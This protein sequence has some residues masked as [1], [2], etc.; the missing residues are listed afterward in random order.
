MTV[1]FRFPILLLISSSLCVFPQTKSDPYPKLGMQSG[2]VYSFNDIETL[3][4]VTGNLTFHI[5]IG[6]LGPDR[7]GTEHSL[8][9]VYNSKIWEPST[10]ETTING[11]AVTNPS[12]QS[13]TTGGWR[14]SMGYDLETEV[15]PGVDQIPCTDPSSGSDLNLLIKY[16]VKTRIVFPDGSR[17]LLRPRVVDNSDAFLEYDNGGDG[18][19]RFY[20]TAQ[21]NYENLCNA[22]VA[23]AAVPNPLIYYSTDGSFLRVVVTRGATTTANP[24]PTTSWAMYFKNGDYVLGGGT[25]AQQ[26]CDRNNNCLTINNVIEGTNYYTTLT[27]DPGRQIK[28]AYTGCGTVSPATPCGQTPLGH[29]T[30]SVDVITIPG[31]NL[32]TL[33]WTVAWANFA[34]SSLTVTS[35]GS[36]GTSRTPAVLGG[37][38]WMV[39]SIQPPVES[40]EGPYSFSYDPNWGRLKKAVSPTGA[41]AFYTYWLE[42]PNA[43]KCIPTAPSSG[44]S[45]AW[46]DLLADY[47]CYN[48]TY[49]ANASQYPDDASAS[50]NSLTADETSTL[51]ISQ[52][53]L[54]GA[55]IYYQSDFTG[56]DGG[57]TTTHFDCA[58]GNN[59]C[60]S[61]DVGPSPGNWQSGLVSQID[62][63]DGTIVV[64]TWAK[65]PLFGTGCASGNTSCAVFPYDSQNTYMSSSSRSVAG[66][67]LIDGNNPAG[68]NATINYAVDLNGNPLTTTENDWD[69]T[70]LRRTSYTY[71]SPTPAATADNSAP[72]SDNPNV[73]WK[74]PGPGILNLPLTKKIEGTNSPIS[75]E[76][77][78]YDISPTPTLGN[79]TT[80]A[81]Y[82]NGPPSQPFAC[83]ASRKTSTADYVTN[84]FFYV[85]N[86]IYPQ[87]GILL[88][89]VDGRGYATQFRYDAD[90]LYIIEKDEACNKA[91][92]DPTAKCVLPEARRSTYVT[93]WNTGKR[94]SA[95]DADN[96]TT[97]N[98]NYSSG[99][100][101]DW[102]SRPTMVTDPAGA[103][104][105]FVFN[106]GVNPRSVKTSSPLDTAPGNGLTG[107]RTVPSVNCYDSVGR[108]TLTIVSEAGVAVD[109]SSTSS[110]VIMVQRQYTYRTATSGCG[111]GSGGRFECVSNPFRSTSDAT[112][113][114]VQ[115]AYDNAGRLTE[116]AHQNGTQTQKVS[117]ATYSYNGYCT[118]AYDE[119]A[120]SGANTGNPGIIK[121]T[122][123]DALGRI[124]FVIEKGK[125]QSNSDS[126]PKTTYAYDGLGNLTSVQQYSPDSAVTQTRTFNYDA[127]GR[128]TTAANPESGTINYRYDNNGNLLAKWDSRPVTTCYWPTTD[129]TA[130]GTSAQS[131][132]GAAGVG[133]DGLNRLLGK[134][135]SDGTP[136]V[137]YTY[138]NTGCSTPFGVGRLTQTTST[139]QWT[140]SSGGTVTNPETVSYTAFDQVGRVLQHSQQNPL[141]NSGTPAQFSY[142]YNQA[143]ALTAMTYPSGRSITTTYDAAG[144]AKG[145]QGALNSATTYYAYAGA[146]L[147]YSPH[148]AISQIS[149]SGGS[150]GTS[151]TMTENRAYNARLQP[152]SISAVSTN[153]ANPALRSFGYT[154]AGGSAPDGADNNGNV[155]SQT[156]SGTG[157]AS[158]V[159][160]TYTYDWA[161]RI[162]GANETVSNWS[163]QFTCDQFGNC[164]TTGTGTASNTPASLGNFST[165]NNRTN[166]N[167]AVYDPAGNQTG[168]GALGMTYDAE[169]RMTGSIIGGTLTIY[170]YDADGQR[171]AKVDCAS[172]DATCTEDSPSAA[173][174]WYVYD[175]HGELAAE[176][177][178]TADTSA[179]TTCYVVADHLGSTRLKA[180]S[181]GA[182]KDCHDYYPFGAEI[183]SST[184]APM[185]R[186][187][188]YSTTGAT[189]VLFTG[190]IRDGET[191]SSA[192]GGLDYFGARYMASAQGRFTSPDLVGPDLLNP[193]TLNKY[194]Y[195]LN[196][197]YRYVDPNG[198]YEE[199]V[200]RGLT[201][202]MAF[203]VGLSSQTAA[204]IASG[205][206]GVDDNPS[207]SPMWPVPC[208]GADKIRA[209]YHF[210][211]DARRA[212]MYSHFEGTL[213]A[214]D[215]GTFLH[216]EQDS[217]SHAGFGPVAG[218][219]SAGT[220]PDKTYND[221]AKA[222]RM[223]KDTYD[224]LIKASG[225]LTRTAGAIDWKAINPYVQRFNRATT[226]K[227]KSKAL[228]ELREEVF[229]FRKEEMIRE[230]EFR[231]T[232]AC[233]AENSSCGPH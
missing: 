227:E 68:T 148:G 160:Q 93:D 173:I 50:S 218:H 71:S 197:P 179:C 188:C 92:S 109:C 73:Y 66:F 189:G 111:V 230:A 135:Y 115:K 61:Y 36:D 87:Y 140:N 39:T 114:W 222:D 157:L 105:S 33:N 45:P 131:T 156:I 22:T 85:Q 14:Y 29:G 163:Q 154:Y 88:A 211:T 128:L 198:M 82:I 23:F 17:H 108:L 32:S 67:T 60:F 104:T 4:H 224:I 120:T 172:G 65:N 27:D 141:M 167:N 113:G 59:Y 42:S 53:A 187:G 20:P 233:Q 175:A 232:G 149:L 205:N 44:T 231:R 196:N 19:Y 110:N 94:R 31:F 217:F 137:A 9:L 25:N 225:L 122:C 75:Y 155:L 76:Q 130:C 165:A 63:P 80:H 34:N 52:K 146:P 100:S 209:D 90:N 98:F 58:N 40:N 21:T 139:K 185:G 89:S 106:D 12:I 101:Y 56:P 1:H 38:G 6:A 102:Q 201:F 144:R 213:S 123:S 174:T 125:S 181:S 51:T 103:A 2:G 127:L 216:A 57:K 134:Q 215:L 81:R 132:T 107:N 55:T 228:T 118:T 177:P 99:S 13:S 192:G 117:R 116:V 147:A 194:R 16:S 28:V 133:Y 84:Q 26:V 142:S 186:G 11:A 153:G 210:T 164:A 48:S 199:D 74:M 171:V 204:R 151:W 121:Q 145:L 124:K 112:M 220:A 119:A 184:A 203:A 95:T 195:A 43:G 129:S 169:N 206:Q 212:A 161:N 86:G 70:L 18:Y 182:A 229:R 54:G 166:V 91:I 191:G 72:S 162:K 46:M 214:A 3:N 158:A 35:T 69:G 7:G 49:Y 168:I 138:C 200:H 97:T 178:G 64:Q 183:V 78:C 226:A 193:Q 223:A 41:T 15:R 152:T 159:T 5:P 221:P 126:Y 30:S 83:D 79:V 208:C 202:A 150:S 207:T 143:G 24:I 77:F 96:S 10:S 8:S 180:D 190:K 62:N 47:P 219:A 136:A 176:Y 37:P 170:R